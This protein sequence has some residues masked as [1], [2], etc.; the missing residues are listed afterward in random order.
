MVFPV[1]AFGVGSWTVKKAEHQ[2]IDA[3]DLWCW[4]R[5]L[6]G[7]WTARLSKQSILRETN[8]GYPLEGLMLKLKLQYF[9]HLMKN[10]QLIGKVS[11]AWKDWRQKEKRA[12]KDETAGWHH[13][14]NGYELGQTSGDGEEHEGL[15]CCSP[16]GCKMLDTTGQ[17]NNKNMSK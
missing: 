6:R 16:W 12:S 11:D 13:W 15:V 9:G 10:S 1:V 3:L 5:F 14:C 4:R 17:L 7:A 8:P 2:R